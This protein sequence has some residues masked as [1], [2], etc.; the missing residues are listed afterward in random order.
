[1]G[2]KLAHQLLGVLALCDDVEALVRQQSRQ[3]MAQQDAVLG[4][5]YAH[6]ISARTR[7]PPPLGVHTRSRP[8]S[9][10]TRSARP[11]SPL[12]RSLSAPPTPS[13][14]TSRVTSTVASLAWACLPML[15]RLSVTT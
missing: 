10:S 4:Q 5:C 6:G 1:M 7:V 14:T 11:R 13:S 3:S 2:R 15:A 9:A 8:P 12:P